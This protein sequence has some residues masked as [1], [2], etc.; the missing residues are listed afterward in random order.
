MRLRTILKEID[1]I[2]TLWQGD[3][4]SKEK[5]LLELAKLRNRIY[6]K[7]REEEEKKGHGNKLRHLMGWY[8]S[9]WDNKPPERL[10]FMNPE[11]IIGKHLKELIAIYEQNGE[12][13]EALK[14]DYERFKQTW[15]TGDKGIMHFRSA[16]PQIKQKDKGFYMSPE[17]S[18][19]VDYYLKQLEEK[20][21]FDD[22]LP[23]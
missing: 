3:I 2:L 16:L 5:A 18:R 6:V 1:K 11:K 10:R 17:A 4:E 22:E 8:L 12:D 20:E 14:R 13:V 19:G 9:L 15:K 23:W 21:A 7:V